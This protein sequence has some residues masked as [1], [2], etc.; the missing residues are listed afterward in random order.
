MTTTADVRER[1]PLELEDALVAVHL[2]RANRDFRGKTFEADEANF[3]EKEAVSCK[4][5]YY[6]APLLWQ[7]IQ[8]RANE[9][10]H[11]LQTFGDLEV[12]QNYWLERSDSIPV[13][14]TESGEV[15]QGGLKWVVV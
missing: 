5:I 3:D 10:E 4:T 9:F 8:N 7:K 11:T 15:A 6:L 1:L 12:F 13:T 14:N 2:Q